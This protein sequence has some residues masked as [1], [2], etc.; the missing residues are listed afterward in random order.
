[1][2]SKIIKDGPKNFSLLV[3][4]I[5]W[6]EFEPTPIIDIGKL[7][8]PREG[9]KGLRLDSAAW[10]VQEKMGLLLWW[11]EPKGEEDLIFPMESRNS[12]RFDDGLISPRKDKGWRGILY[13]SSFRVKE[14]PIP[15]SFLVLLD[16]DK[17]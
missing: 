11:G 1:M 15:K 13:L 6:E 12:L 8:A 14:G 4:G 10:T 16:F 5:V 17:Q 3:K 9:L 7:E 2:I